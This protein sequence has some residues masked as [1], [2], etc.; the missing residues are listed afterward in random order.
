MNGSMCSIFSVVSGNC[1]STFSRMDLCDILAVRVRRALA[2]H[3]WMGC[4]AGEACILVTALRTLGCKRSHGG[5]RSDS[6]SIA[7]VG[8][9]L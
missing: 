7:V 6:I 1:C 2:I 3:W 5:S 4:F 9:V 8:V